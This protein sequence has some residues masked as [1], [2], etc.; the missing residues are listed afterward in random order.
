MASSTSSIISCPASESKSES[1]GL[2]TSISTIIKL[3]VGGI[4]Y[5][6]SIQTLIHVRTS[7]LYTM[8]NT[9]IG[10]KR[11]ESGYYFIDRNGEV[12]QYILSY[13]RDNTTEM[14][15]DLSLSIL[16]QLK[17]ESTYYLLPELSEQLTKL[18]IEKEKN[19]KP[20]EYKYSVISKWLG[21]SDTVP[22]MQKNYDDGWKIIKAFRTHEYGYILI[23]RRLIR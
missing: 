9:S 3:D 19:N 18:I 7:R 10:L 1:K 23:Y 20:H 6:T 14:M 22:T 12:F 15:V 16:K 2:D 4:K 5:T 8:F 21:D 17:L 11:D 13:L